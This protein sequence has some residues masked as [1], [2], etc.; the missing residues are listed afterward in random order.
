MAVTVRC[1]MGLTQLK[2]TIFKCATLRL[3]YIL[4]AI[5][6]MLQEPAVLIRNWDN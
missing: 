4:P 1:V 5:T 2:L 6:E 3:V